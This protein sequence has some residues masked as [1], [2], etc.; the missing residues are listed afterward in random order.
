MIICRQCD[1]KKE[2]LIELFIVSAEKARKAKVPA[3][4]FTLDG[5]YDGNVLGFSIRDKYSQTHVIGINVKDHC[6]YFISGSLSHELVIKSQ[7]DKK[8]WK[9]VAQRIMCETIINDNINHAFDGKPTTEFN[10]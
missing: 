4:L 9:E 6:I 10:M 1:E 8:E 2:R 5:K 7:L 3:I